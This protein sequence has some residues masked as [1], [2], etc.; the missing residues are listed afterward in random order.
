VRIQFIDMKLQSITYLLLFISVNSFC[1]AQSIKCFNKNTT[2]VAPDY[3]FT[4]SWLALPQ[5]QDASDAVPSFDTLIYETSNAD[6]FFIYPTSF[7]SSRND[8]NWNASVFDTVINELSIKRSITYQATIFNA[9]GSVYAPIYRQAHYRSFFT[10]DKVSAAQAL[11]IAYT[12]VRNAFIF[13]LKHY[14]KGKP[15]IIAA[16]SQGAY[17]GRRLLTEFFDHRDCE[18]KLVAAYLIGYPTSVHSFEMIKPCTTATQSGCFISWRTYNKSMVEKLPFKDALC[19]NPLTWDTTGTYASASL[20]K[21]GVFKDFNKLLKKVCDAQIINNYLFCSK[22]AVKGRIFIAQK[23]YHIIDLNLFY[24]NI[25]QNAV[26]RVSA[27][28]KPLK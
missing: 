27:Y 15:I 16:H 14:N 28:L 18:Y 23:N 21:G 6:V 8:S 25:R 24:M 13:Y 22:P 5:M 4:S 12:D 9:A 3:S 2:P 17:H 1:S 26:Q 20:N 7:I 10:D 11:D 19:V